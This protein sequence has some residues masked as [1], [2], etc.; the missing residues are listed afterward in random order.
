[1]IK[2]LALITMLLDHIGI[3]FFPNVRWI[4]YVGRLAMPLFGYCVA[5]GFYYSKEHGTLKKYV[6]N[7][8]ILTIVSE[9]PYALMEQRKSIDIG[10]TWLISVSLLYVLESSLGKIKKYLAAGLILLFAAGLYM[11]ISFDFGIYGSLTAVCMYYLMIKKDEPYSMF[12]ALVILWA[13]YVLVMR[14]SFEQFFAVFAI[15]F[16]ALL[17]PIDNKLKLPKKLYY[18]FYPVHITLLLILERIIA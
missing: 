15:I 3:I 7:L 2:L 14:Q 9:V 10:L 16:I 4:R 18:W 17:K 1:M 11:F 12:L 6:Q 13:F 5:R 8:I